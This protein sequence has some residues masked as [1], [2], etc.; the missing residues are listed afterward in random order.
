MRHLLER[1]GE[2]GRL[3]DAALVEALL[4]HEWPLNVR[5]LNNF[6]SMAVVGAAPGEPLELSP[7]LEQALASERALGQGPTPTPAPD[8]GPTP[9]PMPTRGT[10]DDA[11]PALRVPSAAE[12]E[13]VLERFQGSVTH[14][15]RHLGCSRQQLYRW[16]DAHGMK[17]DRF[18]PL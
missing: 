10:A 14:A 16:L 6:L 2:A 17:L 8:P 7:R 3:L 13:S 9:T 4:L 18:R 5:G 12:L 1:L 11:P 15:A